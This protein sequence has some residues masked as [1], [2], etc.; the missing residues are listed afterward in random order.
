MPHGL[1]L[2]DDGKIGVIQGFPGKV[3]ILNADDTPGGEIH[4]GGTAEEGGF[5]FVRELTKSG[6][7]LVGARG[8]ATFD[9]GTAKSVIDRAP[10]RSWIFKART[11]SSSSNTPRKATCSGRSSTRQPNSPNWTSGPAG[12]G[13]LY[14]APVSEQY[15]INVRNLDGEIV[16]VMSRQ[17]TPRKRTAE[18]KDELT[19]GMVIVMNGVRQEIENKALDY[20]PAI[21]GM[22]V[23]RDGRLYVRGCYDQDDLLD[24]FAEDPNRLGIVVADVTGKGVDAGMV[25]GMTKS[26]IHALSEQNLTTRELILKLNRHLCNLLKKQKFISLVYAEYSA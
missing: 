5:N 25:M 24:T 12:D 7:H 11:R 15:I 2:L 22:T 10:W 8:R 16:R 21:M 9:I 26:T 23:A 1:I 4:I 14:T 3:T 17:F 13:I 18:D 19:S 20:D 6:N